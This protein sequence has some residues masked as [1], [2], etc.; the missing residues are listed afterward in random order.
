VGSIP[1]LYYRSSRFEFLHLSAAPFRIV[2]EKL[3]SHV[4]NGNLNNKPHSEARKR[5]MA[6]RKDPKVIFR[7]S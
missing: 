1:A 4:V 5:Y 6:P 3:K 2:V 7:N